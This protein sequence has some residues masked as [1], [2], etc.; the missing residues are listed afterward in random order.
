MVVFSAGKILAQGIALTL[1]SFFVFPCVQPSLASESHHSIKKLQEELHQH[2][3]EYN[4]LR[5]EWIRNHRKEIRFRSKG[6]DLK[7]RILELKMDKENL[8]VKIENARI[9]LIRMNRKLDFFNNKI[10]SEKLLLESDRNQLEKTRFAYLSD[11]LKGYLIELDQ[12]PSPLFYKIALLSLSSRQNTLSKRIAIEKSNEIRSINE[13]SSWRM[14]KKRLLA[15]RQKTIK[16]EARERSKM[17]SMRNELKHLLVMEQ[18][19]K[20]DDTRIERKKRHLLHLIQHLEA[21]SSHYRSHFHAVKR[22]HLLPGSLKWPVRGEIVEG[23]GHFHD[24]VDIRVH[25][26]EVIHSS[27]DGQVIFAR[28]YTGYGQMVI[29]DHGNHIYSLYGHLGR[30]AVKK[31]ENISKGAVIGYAGGGGSHGKDTL[32]FGLTHGGN[33]VNPVPYLSR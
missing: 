3:S 16:K 2:R 19:L 6:Q 14:K 12:A 7:Y 25:P 1:I 21:I 23:F 15:D 29:L 20:K 32:F 5:K 13:L 30:I 31:G 26:G 10:S 8:H 17:N 22:L 24:G 11:A 18:R 28:H 27:G 9:D 4:R 33:P